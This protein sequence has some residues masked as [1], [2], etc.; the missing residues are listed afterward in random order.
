ME[1][2]PVIFNWIL[3][4][5]SLNQRQYHIPAEAAIKKSETEKRTV[6]SVMMMGLLTLV[7]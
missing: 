7:S 4:E 6:F 5:K 3:Q 1:T 2:N